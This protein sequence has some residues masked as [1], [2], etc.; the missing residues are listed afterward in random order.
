[1]ALKPLE[2][3]TSNIATYAITESRI[4]NY[5]P[6]EDAQYDEWAEN[7]AAKLPAIAT[8]IGGIPHY[9]ISW[10]ALIFGLI[11]PMGVALA[12]EPSGESSKSPEKSAAMGEIVITATK[13]KQPINNAPASVSV[14]TA[15]EIE[16]S[17]VSTI[18]DLFRLETGLDVKRIAGL[19]SAGAALP[20]R[21]SVRGI[22][23]PNRVLILVDGLPLN[24][25]G[26]NFVNLNE[27]S[28]QDVERV[29]IVRGP[30][31]SLY[32]TNAGSG[33]IN[34]MTRK[35]Q[36]NRVA[37]QTGN[38][39]YSHTSTRGSYVGRL[40]NFSIS[41]DMRRIDNYLA[42]DYIIRRTWHAGPGSF[43]TTRLPETNH[44]YEDRR[45][46][47]RLAW[48]VTKHAIWTL[49]WRYF[50]NQ[51]GFGQTSYLSL[52]K[53]IN[54]KSQ[55]NFAALSF[56][57]ELSERGPFSVSLY[58]RRNTT[59]FWNES[60]SHMKFAPPPPGP[61]YVSS[62]D[63]SRYDDW[64]LSL[65]GSKSLNAQH[66]M[67]LGLENIWNQCQSDPTEN[68]TTGQSLP[69]AKRM[70][71][72]ISNGG[73]FIQ[74]EMVLNERF[75][76]VPAVRFDKHSEFGWAVSPKMGL[77]YNLN[78]NTRLRV[79][80]GQAF[81][82]PTIAQ[83][84]APD[85]MPSPGV[86]LRSNPNLAPEHIT[87]FELG[88]ER[89]LTNR[90]TVRQSLFH[91]NIVDLISYR[92]LAGGIRQY[93]NLDKTKSIGIESVLDGRFSDGLT[94]SINHTYQDTEDQETHREQDYMP[95]NKFNWVLKLDRKFGAIAVNASV[96]ESYIGGRH[97]EDWQSGRV[98]TLGSYWKTDLSIVAEYKANTSL[99]FDIQN[100][101]NKNYE[102]TGGYLSPGRLYSIGLAMK[103]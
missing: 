2:V 60:Y 86:T 45:L 76:L 80:G 77:V 61:V 70:D 33:V 42:R 89:E 50:D 96:A 52:P 8:L 14:I 15:D 59:E 3:K 53:D 44:D 55:M 35:V 91:N 75:N 90:L 25:S 68:V 32:G 93:D 63:K 40:L 84:F 58:T 82:A 83:L 1:M 17:G 4:A 99:R 5:I 26:T 20:M 94:S 37:Y 57:T 69:S 19:G 51:L 28:V 64:C 100:L 78:Q 27:I 88:G 18:D 66:K 65:Q 74:D 24:G 97:Y 62:Y 6:R 29:E 95:R 13:T 71:E 46:N 101:T 54:I 41:A 36:P 102:D 92:T 81:Q 22:P 21:I 67:T 10:L 98:N 49:Q 34:I 56:E 11:I 73:L 12:Q 23:G 103:F 31:S 87:S 16:S 7:F 48:T 39:S 43:V 38:E 72:S 47:G 85:Y 30:F 9:V 79:S